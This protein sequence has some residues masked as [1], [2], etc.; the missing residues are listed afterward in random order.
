MRTV[1]E[2]SVKE[3]NVRRRRERRSWRDEVERDSSETGK[4]QLEE[5]GTGQGEMEADNSEG[6]GSH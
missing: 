5:R 3:E 1:D 6:E 2:S 4:P